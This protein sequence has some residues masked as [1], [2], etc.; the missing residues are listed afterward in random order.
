MSPV[1]RSSERVARAARTSTLAAGRFLTLLDP[2]WQRVRPHLFGTLWGR[3]VV[4]AVTAKVLFA[5]ASLAA[6]PSSLLTVLD[7]L[8][9]AILI[10][11]GVYLVVRLLGSARRRLLW[12]VRRKLILS[13]VFIGFVPSI[14]IVVFFVGAGL[15]T[16][17]NVSSYLLKSGLE[18]LTEEVRLVA[19]EVAL[20]VARAADPEAMTRIL[21]EHQASVSGRWPEVSFALVPLADSEAGPAIPLAAGTFGPWWH[22]DP[23]TTLPAWVSRAGFGGLVAFRVPDTNETEMTVRAAGLPTSRDATFAVII[24][25][26]VDDEITERLEE[27][28]GIELRSVGVVP[29][30]GE[31][32]TPLE[33]RRRGA[34]DMVGRTQGSRSGYTVSWVTF[35]DYVDWETGRT[36]TVGVSTDVGIAA[37]WNAISQSETRL[38]DVNLGDLFL[39]ALALIGGLF[40]VIE[41]VALGMGFVLARSIT[42][43]VHELFIG[44]ERVRLGDFSHRLR[45]KSDDQLGQL[46][47]SFND[48]TAS[49]EDLLEQADEKK[50]LEEELRIAHEMQLSLL[51]DGPLEIPGL[52]MTTLCKPAREVGGD[53]FDYFQLSDR[54]VGLLIAD[55]SGKGASAAFYMAVLKGL[56]LSLSLVHDSPRA[57]LIAANRV[58]SRSLDDRSFITMTYAIL[59][60]EARSLV[61]ARA[62]HTPLIHLAAD[63]HGRREAQVLTPDGMVLGLNLPGIDEKFSEVLEERS[64]AIDTDDILVFFTD[65]VSEAMNADDDLFG[66]DRLSRL[67]E[68][69]AELSSDALRERIVREVEAFV[70]GADQHDDMTMVLLKIVDLD[71][72][73]A[74]R[75][76]PT[77]IAV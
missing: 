68:D 10:L 48:M 34:A 43:S 50:R 54:R 23:P 46:G 4:T 39:L 74:T 22:L 6:T 35:A 72:L 73:G 47:V 65:G 21:E 58:L 77:A 40:L 41:V 36:G 42:G 16:M 3:L 67:V 19:D 57:L 15:F 37:L 12:R 75:P 51:P 55:V 2:F 69:H 27:E 45:M 5:L 53:Y 33:G 60:L 9:T 8:A 17:L 61:Y 49:I 71:A 32:V 70:D 14:L 66:E 24:D 28:T 25:V 31:A 44:T 38:G 30:G 64:L 56:M 52:T 20:E 26:P 59:D 29:I 62:G 1:Q 13:Y 18:N 7:G 11:V 63:E 76:G